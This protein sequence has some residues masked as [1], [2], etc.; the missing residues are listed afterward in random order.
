M[1]PLLQGHKKTNYL[2]CNCNVA[3]LPTHALCG[4]MHCTE[5]MENINL[6]RILAYSLLL[7]IS[8]QFTR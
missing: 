6:N 5:N 7:A 8:Y 4:L 1:N 3:K 2:V